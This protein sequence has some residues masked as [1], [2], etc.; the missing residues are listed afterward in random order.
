MEKFPHLKLAKKITGAPRLF[1][2]GGKSQKSKDNLRN[3]NSHGN[4][5]KAQTEFLKKTWGHE[6]LRREELGLPLLDSN[7]I[8]VFLKVDPSSFDVENA[9]SGFNISV[10]SENEDGYIIGASF[11]GLQGLQEKIRKFIEIKGRDQDQASQ[12][13]EIL[14]ETKWRPE[15]ILSDE[16]LK[17]WED[18]ADDVIYVV[19]IAIACYMQVMQEPSPNKRGYAKKAYKIYRTVNRAR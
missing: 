5:L 13:W 9:F 8:P 14:S 7:I 17:I 3:R 6:L 11:D 19:D 2:G 10:I 16:L 4:Y 15:Y 1:G 18:I 12:L